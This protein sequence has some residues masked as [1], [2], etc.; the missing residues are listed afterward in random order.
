MHIQKHPHKLYSKK[1]SVVKNTNILY[2]QKNRL[3]SLIIEVSLT[4]E[5]VKLLNHKLHYGVNSIA[6]FSFDVAMPRIGI[7]NTSLNLTI[8]FLSIQ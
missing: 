5:C 3:D 8:R 4:D 6:L 7:Q 2:I 1:D